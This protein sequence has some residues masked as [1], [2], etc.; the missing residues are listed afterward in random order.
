MSV[1][2]PHEWEIAIPILLNLAECWS[3]RPLVRASSTEIAEDEGLS[4]KGW[5]MTRILK[6]LVKAK[7]I[8]HTRKRPMG[9]RLARTPSRITMAQVLLAAQERNADGRILSHLGQ[10]LPR[11]EIRRLRTSRGAACPA[12]FV[13]ERIDAVAVKAAASITV[14]RAL[15]EN[16]GLRSVQLHAEQYRQTRYTPAL[17]DAVRPVLMEFAPLVETMNGVLIAWAYREVSYPVTRGFFAWKDEV[18][19][20][21]LAAPRK[22]KDA[23]LEHLRSSILAEAG[24]AGEEV[25]ASSSDRLFLRWERALAEDH[26]NAGGVA[27]LE[28]QP[29]RGRPSFEILA[30]SRPALAR[31]LAAVG[32]AKPDS[33]RPPIERAVVGGLVTGGCWS[34]IDRRKRVSSRLGALLDG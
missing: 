24:D 21:R 28:V 12:A 4:N 26:A 20:D 16:L 33:V 27:V 5:G 6:R 14:A 23:D 18:D 22:L 13:L 15:G 31:A 3:H 25:A 2:A 29:W 32:I 19:P 7:V 8:T 10:V 9:Y 11:S 34:Y 30:S 17:L 1:R